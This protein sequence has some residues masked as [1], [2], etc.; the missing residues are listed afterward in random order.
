M[1]GD[2]SRSK[3]LVSLAT[4]LLL[5]LLL[6]IIFIAAADQQHT[7]AANHVNGSKS[8]SQLNMEVVHG[9]ARSKEQEMEVGGQREEDVAVATRSTSPQP[10]DE[11]RLF[12]ASAHEVPSG[13]NPISNR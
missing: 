13:P 9:G 8:S 1:A 11:T 10:C 2:E 4:I 5:L 12:N 3:T 7:S 6:F